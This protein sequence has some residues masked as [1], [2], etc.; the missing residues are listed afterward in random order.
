MRE[1]KPLKCTQ[2]EQY[3]LAIE[4]TGAEETQKE[5]SSDISRPWFKESCVHRR[6]VSF[7]VQR[8]P[9]IRRRST[10]LY[11]CFLRHETRNYTQEGKSFE[12]ETTDP[13]SIA[14][15]NGTRNRREGVHRK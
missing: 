14:Y 13:A 6:T 1:P 12:R 10:I 4:E 2:S 11:L 7:V 8:I 9:E 3:A 5:I 15:P